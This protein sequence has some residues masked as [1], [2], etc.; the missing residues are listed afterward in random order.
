[1]PLYGSGS[2]SIVACVFV[3]AGIC[4]PSRCL[5]MNVYSELVFQRSGVIS[6]YDIFK[7]DPALRILRYV[8]NGASTVR[9]YRTYDHMNR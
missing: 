2:Y 7:Q 6:Q 9:T 1:V 4:L 3:A 5:G 8:H